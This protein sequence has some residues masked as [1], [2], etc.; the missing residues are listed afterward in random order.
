MFLGS[1]DYVSNHSHATN[2]EV[3]DSLPHAA[4]CT[5]VHVPNKTVNNE[6]FAFS[7]VFL[8]HN[9]SISSFSAISFILSAAAMAAALLGLN[10]GTSWFNCW[11]APAET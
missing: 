8:A 6:K 4:V 9:S 10:V 1:L 3:S 7:S 2:N 11:S 5:K